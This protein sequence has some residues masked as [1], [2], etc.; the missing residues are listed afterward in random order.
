MKRHLRSLR[1]FFVERVHPYCRTRRHHAFAYY[2]AEFNANVTAA[3][4]LHWF[5]ALAW[6]L[7]LKWC[8][9]RHRPSW[10]E[11]EV[12]RRMK[13]VVEEN[14]RLRDRISEMELERFVSDRQTARRLDALSERIEHAADTVVLRAEP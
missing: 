5:V 7:N 14:N 1:R 9:Y 2:S 8:A 12:R 4:P 3:W 10:I 11:Q 13:D 6:W